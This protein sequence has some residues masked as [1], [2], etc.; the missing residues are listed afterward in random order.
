[1][2]V[3]SL[4]LLAS[5]IATVVVCLSFTAKC[6]DFSAGTEGLVADMAGTR[7]VDVLRD[8]AVDEA[9]LLAEARIYPGSLR[10]VA[11]NYINY[12][13]PSSLWDHAAKMAGC[14]HWSWN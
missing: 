6:V 4:A 7:V 14:P 11:V 10:S 12:G 8:D 5:V 3:I 13:G 1:M 2:A 9:G